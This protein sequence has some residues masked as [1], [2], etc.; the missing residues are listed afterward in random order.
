MWIRPRDQRI[1]GQTLAKARLQAGLAQQQLARKLGKP[2][3][4][5]SA[6][7]NGQRRTD[8]L[9]FIHIARALGADAAKLFR[10]IAK[11]G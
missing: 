4:F 8:V 3:S 7:E 5:V 10:K 11:N 1:V 6:Y 2:Q 9:E